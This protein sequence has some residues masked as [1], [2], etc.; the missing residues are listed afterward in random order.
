MECGA[1]IDIHD[2]AGKKCVAYARENHF[3]STV[4]TLIR[5]GVD[6]QPKPRGGKK[7]KTEAERRQDREEW[8][9]EQKA[10]QE[11]EAET[12]AMLQA[13]MQMK[14]AANYAAEVEYSQEAHSVNPQL[15]PQPPPNPHDLVKG[16]QSKGGYT[17]GFGMNS[18]GKNMDKGY[19]KPNSG[20]GGPQQSNKGGYDLG[21]G[22]NSKGTN[23]NSNMGYGSSQSYGNNNN[24]ASDFFGTSNSYSNSKPSAN[25]MYGNGESLSN[26]TNTIANPPISSSNVHSHTPPPASSP[27]PAPTE[28]QKTGMM[29]SWAARVRGE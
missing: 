9:K 15:F 11:A 23:S 22:T 5:F 18:K 2:H 12:K 16:A 26:T 8:E 14:S 19:G 24:N 7:R 4:L 6:E 25:N 21:F 27:P 13:G 29:D 3:H 20:F 10:R 28:A 17:L 1:D